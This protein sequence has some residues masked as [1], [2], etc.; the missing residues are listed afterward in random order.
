MV[1]AVLLHMTSTQN[2]AI[3]RTTQVHQWVQLLE[4]LVV[5]SPSVDATPQQMA[6]DLPHELINEVNAQ[7]ALRGCSF[8]VQESK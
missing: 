5:G 4:A 1:L 7:L 3:S 6:E 2:Q 8:R